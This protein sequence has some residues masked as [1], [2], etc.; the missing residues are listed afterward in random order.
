MG[1]KHAVKHMLKAYNWDYMTRAV[2]INPKPGEIKVHEF[3]Y[4]GI[5][6]VVYEENGVIIRSWP[7]IHACDG[8][9]SLVRGPQCPSARQLHRFNSARGPPKGDDA[10]GRVAWSIFGGELVRLVPG[11]SSRRAGLLA[12]SS[13]STSSPAA[14]PRRCMRT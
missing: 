6:E 1:T 8:P 13:P 7:C 2:T 12:T 14:Q 4:R 10:A 9:V 11:R 5:N 3:D